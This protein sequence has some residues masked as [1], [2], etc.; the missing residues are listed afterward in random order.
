MARH[1]LV[2][3]FLVLALLAA[4]GCAPSGSVTPSLRPA[5]TAE[6]IPNDWDLAQAVRA[7]LSETDRTGFQSVSVLAWRGTVLLTGAVVRPGQRL[8]AQQL[9]AEIPGV[10]R[11]LV[12]LQLVEARRLP[13]FPP[14]PARERAL[15]V[16]LDGLP[17]QYSLR[18][19]HGI[20]YLLGSAPRRADAD[21]AADL[22]READGVKWVVDHTTADDGG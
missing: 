19:V 22:I 8:R 18:V 5:P 16:S 1:G 15:L 12:D 10:S 20:V 3:A 2:E 17:G 21:R 4:S 13:E 9:A 11:V 14:D 7:R 6:A